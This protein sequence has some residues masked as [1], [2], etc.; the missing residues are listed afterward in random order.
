MGPRSR[1][2]RQYALASEGTTSTDDFHRRMP[3]RVTL[4]RVLQLEETRV[5]FNDWVTRGPHS[6]RVARRSHRRPSG[7]RVAR[8]RQLFAVSGSCGLGVG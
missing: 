8:I 1:I 6:E 2:R 5:P 7:R 4:D 3:S